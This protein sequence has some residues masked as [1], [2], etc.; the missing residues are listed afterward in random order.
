MPLKNGHVGKGGSPALW[1]TSIYVDLVP[2][3]KRLPLHDL[4][5]DL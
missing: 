2:S 1:R 4:D 5:I 3:E